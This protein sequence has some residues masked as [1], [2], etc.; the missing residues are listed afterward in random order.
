MTRKFAFLGLSA[1][2]LSVS[3]CGTENAS[4]PVSGEPL[5]KVAAPQ[6][7]SWTDTVSQ[8]EAG[9]Y[10][11]GNPDAQLK[12]VEYGAITCPGCAQFHVESKAELEEMVA[13]GVVSFEFRPYLVHGIQDV[14]GFLLAKCNGAEAFFGLADQMYTR[15]AEWLGRL[16]TMSDAERQQAEGLKP[17][18]LIKFL[19]NKFDLVNFVKPLGVSEDA[20]NQ[21]LSNQK[22]FED[23]VKQT[24]TAQKDA[25]VTGTP[26]FRLN[27]GDRNGGKW[28][29]A[30]AALKNAGARE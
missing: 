8:T 30:K 26:S 15:Q 27:G 2:A 20:A 16:Q 13:T 11:M 25:N 29:A 1:I 4:V 3:A 10:L 12:L 24:E 18:E 28:S 19:A 6:G 23:F 17:T 9:G 14:P 21:C 22:T 5:E 7:Q